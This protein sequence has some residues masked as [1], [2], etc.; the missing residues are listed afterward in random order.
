MVVPTEV[1]LVTVVVEVVLMEIRI[2]QLSP[3][4]VE[5]PVRGQPV[6]L[7]MVLSEEMEVELFLSKL[8]Q[9]PSMAQY[10]QT[11]QMG[12]LQPALVV[13]VEEPEVLSN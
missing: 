10:L 1:P 7:A 11:V 6:D 3:W 2:S 13:A 12:L 5:E 4:E 8:T 9:L